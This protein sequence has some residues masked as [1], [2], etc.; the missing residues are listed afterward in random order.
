MLLC[1]CSNL[2][3]FAGDRQFERVTEYR[4]ELDRSGEEDVFML[5]SFETSQ[6]SL[7]KMDIEV[8]AVKKIFSA[9]VKVVYT[10]E[11]GYNMLQQYNKPQ[12]IYS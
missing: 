10:I 5:L 7:H 9:A 2:A 4:W 12:S 6:L 3:W 1:Y 8:S 11:W